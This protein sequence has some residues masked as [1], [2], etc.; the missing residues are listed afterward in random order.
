MTEASPSSAGPTNLIQWLFD[1]PKRLVDYV[2]D[3]L[4][5]V[6]VWPPV[7]KGLVVL[8]RPDEL[9]P[10]VQVALAARAA[11]SL[12]QDPDLAFCYD[13]LNKVSRSF[14]V[15]IQQLPPQLRDP[16]C[17]FYLVLRALDTVEDDMAI[18][19]DIK[20]PL[21][22]TF[23]E[24]CHNREWTMDCG[25]KHY[26]RL[27]LNYPKVVNAFQRLEKQ[28]QEVIQD[29]C[30]RMGDGM[31]E[32]IPIE[33]KTVAEYEKY[34]HYVA[35]LVG[36][37]LS[38][39][40][41]ASGIEG[42]EFAGEEV[43]SNHMGLFLQKTNI[44][45]DYLE[46]IVEEPAP[47]MFWPREIWGKY[48]DELDAFKDPKNAPAAV[49]CLNDMVTDALKHVPY[50]LQYLARVR[51]WN[52]FRFCAIPQVMAIGT[53]GLCYGNPQVFKGV[54][55]MRRGLT[56]KYMSDLVSMRDVFEI[57]DH[58]AGEIDKK[59]QRVQLGQKAQPRAVAVHTA[60]ECASIRKLCHDGI[61]TCTPRKRSAAKIVLKWYFNL[62]ALA[63]IAFLIIK[64]LDFD[65]FQ[66]GPQDP[67]LLDDLEEL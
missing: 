5:A 64:F 14:A 63:L 29:I 22:H 66:Y 40:W 11:K 21:L 30:K 38:D 42:P 54:V 36:I 26:R 8:S 7:R 60:E 2:Y 3:D 53:L 39:L 61:A 17:I 28:Y 27:M 19:Q 1:Q 23:H 37:G 16:V 31:A 25:E 65:I 43:L 51:D 6:R 10:L 52:I 13:M 47:R 49:A 56:A 67:P 41:S 46:D 50:C 24:K 32:F 34:C 18:P 62:M 12:P 55:K 58:W 20:I 35:G 15:V 45:R 44:I 48:A 59:A 4:V 33:V 9:L 57:F